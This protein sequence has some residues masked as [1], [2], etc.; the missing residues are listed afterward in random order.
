MKGINF[1]VGDTLVNKKTLEYFTI[2][3][4]IDG[5]YYPEKDPMRDKYC[6]RRTPYI[7]IGNE[8]EWKLLSPPRFTVGYKVLV[9]GIRYTITANDKGLYHYRSKRD[10]NDNVSRYEWLEKNAYCLNPSIAVMIKNE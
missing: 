2:Y 7:R 3:K 10:L 6:D 8:D 5:Y 4:I 1:K 9:N